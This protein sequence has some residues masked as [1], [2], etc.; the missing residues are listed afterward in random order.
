M[1][2]WLSLVQWLSPAFPT[3][4]YAYSHGLEQVISDGVVRSGALAR[5]SRMRSSC[6]RLWSRG[7]ISMPWQEC[8]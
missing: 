8:A 6:R 1:N 7:R 4:G 5:G 2:G 3:G